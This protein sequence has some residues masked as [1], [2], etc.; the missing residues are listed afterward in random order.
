MFDY[1]E[2]LVL[3]DS[4]R[5]Q[6]S[7][8]CRGAESAPAPT[9][10]RGYRESHSSRLRQEKSLAERRAGCRS[11]SCSPSKAS[12][13]PSKTPT[14]GST[15]HSLDRSVNHKTPRT[16]SETSNVSKRI[17]AN[18]NTS[19]TSRTT[20]VVDC[21][22][23]IGHKKPFVTPINKRSALKTGERS[24]PSDS[25]KSPLS[26]KLSRS[27]VKSC[28]AEHT[29]SPKTVSAT[30]RV[31]R[32]PILLLPK[33]DL[34]TSILYHLLF[35]RLHHIVACLSYL[36]WQLLITVIAVGYLFWTATKAAPRSGENSRGVHT[37]S[38][39]PRLNVKTVPDAK[40]IRQ[41]SLQPRVG[42]RQGSLDR[43][44]QETRYLTTSNRPRSS[45][46]TFI[47]DWNTAIVKPTPTTSRGSI[48]VATKNPGSSKYIKTLPP[49]NGRYSV[50]HSNKSFKPQ[51]EDIKSSF[52]L[53]NNK[54][55][56]RNNKAQP[57]R[58]AQQVQVCKPQPLNENERRK[59]LLK[60][61]N[62]F[63]TKQ[64]WNDSKY[65]RIEGLNWIPW[66]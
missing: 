33:I 10:A 7:P 5:R 44:P 66:K 19:A 59:L 15:P 55:T 29:T 63:Q 42:L 22:K 62:N 16:T 60:T 12:R 24:K 27:P 51:L 45:N 57:K 36:Q 25:E 20:F 40:S 30:E 3:F 58:D 21:S 17:A 53:M 56:D 41:K 32:R 6:R 54:N 46:T 9:S 37:S 65:D 11:K 39:T 61:M 48:N 23:N 1:A 8:G 4:P 13:S 2:S 34:A 35:W 31:P 43:N 49:M 64:F 18:T 50:N 38:D 52:L 26:V 47:R 28:R 14:R